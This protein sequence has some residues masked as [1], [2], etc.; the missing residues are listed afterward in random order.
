MLFK[1]LN[2]GPD[3]SL[4]VLLDTSKRPKLGAMRLSAQVGL[5][6]VGRGRAALHGA[7]TGAGSL[8]DLQTLVGEST[9]ASR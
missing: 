1:I 7:Q 5:A 2:S 8:R 6:L 3:L 4:L 9:V